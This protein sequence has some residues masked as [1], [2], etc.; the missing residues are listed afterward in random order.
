MPRVG[1]A[2]RVRT[3]TIR[4]HYQW[5]GE[6]ASYPFQIY[7]S[8]T[9]R[10]TKVIGPFTEEDSFLAADFEELV[11]YEM[12]MRMGPVLASLQESSFD[13]HSLSR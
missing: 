13:L 11:D 10:S 7:Y 4:L 9:S 5:S 8:L 3:G 12:E 2:G 6:S 1:A